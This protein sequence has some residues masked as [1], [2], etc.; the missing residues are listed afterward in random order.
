MGRSGGGTERSG[1]R[2]SGLLRRA[3]GRLAPPGRLAGEAGTSLPAGRSAGCTRLAA[4]RSAAHPPGSDEAEEGLVPSL[5][6]DYV[7]GLRHRRSIGVITR[8]ALALIRYDLV[9]T[10]R[11]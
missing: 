4:P 6:I 1:A 2:R 10:A 8:Y 11:C 3:S 7:D 5:V 9:M